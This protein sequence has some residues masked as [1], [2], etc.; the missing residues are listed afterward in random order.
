M[1]TSGA[2]SAGV[3][4][5]KRLNHRLLYRFWEVQYI[6]LK[7]LHISAG[8]LTEALRMVY[9]QTM[10][11]PMTNETNEIWTSNE[12]LNLKYHSAIRF[13]NVRT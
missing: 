10:Q 9:E 1:E 4:Q 3:I 8:P 6:E 13:R 5:I 2:K 12:K 7:G 11:V